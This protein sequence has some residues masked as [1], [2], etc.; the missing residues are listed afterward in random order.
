MVLFGVVT[1]CAIHKRHGADMNSRVDTQHEFD[2]RFRHGGVQ[3]CNVVT[4]FA[5]GSANAR[6][7]LDTHNGVVRS[8][9]ALCSSQTLQT[10]ARICIQEL[11]YK[12]SFISFLVGILM[13]FYWR[14]IQFRI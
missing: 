8:C 13:G 4:L 6:S 1:L 9:N 5:D 7:L 12:M 11:I 3:S 14:F 2:I 10:L